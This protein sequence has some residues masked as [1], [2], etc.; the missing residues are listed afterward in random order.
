M[1]KLTLLIGLFVLWIKPVYSQPKRLN[2]ILVKKDMEVVLR[3]TSFI[4]KRDTLVYLTDEE[5]KKMKVRVNPHRTS[6]D[7]YDSLRLRSQENSFTKDVYA[8]VVKKKKRKKKLISIVVKSETIFKPYAGYRIATI[9]FKSVDLLEG[10]VTDTLQH[11]TSGFGKF[12]NKVHRDTRARI[13][14]QNLLFEVGDEVDPYQLADNERVL[15]QFITLRDARIYLSKNP[16][17][18][19]EVDVVIV[20]QDVTSIGVSGDY[21]SLKNFRFDVYDINTLGYARQF[22]LSYYR[23]LSAT[24]RHGYGVLLRDPNFLHSFMQ[25]E[26]EYT[27]ADVRQRARVSL[28]RDFFTPQI[29][30]AGGMEAYRTTEDF[31]FEDYDTLR[32]P[33]TENAIDF[34]AGRS[35]E[36]KKR[37]NLI[38]STRVNT[39]RFIHRPYV[40]KDSNSYFYNRTLLLASVS[41][42]KRNFL[43][44]IR[45]RGFGKTEDLPIGGSVN[46]IGGKEINEFIDRYYIEL[47]GTY[48]HYF[49]ALGY[50]NL[51]FALGSF[52]KAGI[53]EDGLLICNGTYFTNLIKLRRAE[54][55]QFV[56]VNYIKGYNRVLDQTVRTAGK[57]EDALGQRPLGNERLS[58]GFETVYFMPWYVYG[59]QFALFHRFDLNLLTMNA[60]LF[61]RPSAFPSI[62]IG[63]HTLNENLVLPVFSFDLAYYGKNKIYVAAWEFRFSTTLRN[64]F[65][66]S[67]AFKPT[68]PIFN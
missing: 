43:T 33:Y 6:S 3:D 49:S 29:R 11:A 53:N 41:F 61:S 31:L 63:V 36:F 52:Y 15:R 1:L 23:H 56:Y 22:Q 44:T 19:N 25:A 59:F 7:F 40:S 64:L 9:T 46:L 60:S 42:T 38:F 32:V 4:T 2:K 26:L 68:V 65:G 58:M 35:I 21:R 62:R 54:V 16:D 20:T 12:V 13:V 34:W 45:I 47:N 14:V 10:S 24:T 8:F 50:F 17:S 57:W 48:N 18:M 37:M 5:A 51:L 55:R 27:D 30:Y 28:G 67:Q 66:T 39:R